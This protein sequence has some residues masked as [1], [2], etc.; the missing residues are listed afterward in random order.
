MIVFQGNLDKIVSKLLTERV[1]TEHANSNKT[2]EYVRD[3][4]LEVD[5]G[6]REQTYVRVIVN[7][8]HHIRVYNAHHEFNVDGGQIRLPWSADSTDMTSV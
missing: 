4:F 3:I 7:T 2:A 5:E 8:D 6:R 1:F